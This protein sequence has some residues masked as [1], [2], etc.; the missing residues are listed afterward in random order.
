MHVVLCACG[1]NIR[2]LLRYLQHFLRQILAQLWRAQAMFG[3]YS[4]RRDYFGLLEA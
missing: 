1:Q 4:P 3:A 2:L